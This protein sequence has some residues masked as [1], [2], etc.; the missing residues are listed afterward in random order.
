[1][2]WLFE[3]KSWQNIYR[4]SA[5]I[6]IIGVRTQGILDQALRIVQVDEVHSKKKEQRPSFTQL[7]IF[8]GRT[9]TFFTGWYIKKNRGSPVELNATYS[10]Q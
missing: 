10:Y 4:V 6:Y 7:L 1:M 5:S 3:G 8:I 9:F 2:L